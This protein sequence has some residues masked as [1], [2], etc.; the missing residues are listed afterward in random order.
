MA[1]VRLRSIVRTALAFLGLVVLAI[2][3]TAGTAVAKRP[4][5]A[6][7]Q[8]FDGLVNGHRDTAGPVTIFVGCRNPSQT[9]GHPVGGTVSVVPAVTSADQSGN[10]GDEGTEIEA[11][12]GA[13]PP[14]IAAPAAKTTAT[15]HRYG[16]ARPIPKHLV[17]PCSGTGQVTFVPFPRA[18]PTS[19]AAV[20]AV[21]YLPQP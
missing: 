3:L 2:A 17:L 13:P 20:V 4:R 14:A 21:R 12:F 6:P 9:T 1:D 7:H 11:F 8:T 16:Q 19:R 15:F 18:V 10:T 5:I